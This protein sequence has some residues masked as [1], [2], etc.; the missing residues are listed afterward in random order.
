[1]TLQIFIT[2]LG[3]TAAFG[4]IALRT[5]PQLGL[6]DRPHKYGFKRK[7]IPY[8]GGVAMIL[9]FFV[10]VM[11]FFPVDRPVLAVLLGGGLLGIVSFVD[12]RQGLPAWFRLVVQVVSAVL[13]VLGGIG[14]ASITN[15]LG[16]TIVLDSIQ[17]PVSLGTLTFTITLF[18]DL[19]TVVW[20]LTMVN[21]FNWIDGVPGMANSV[22]AV[23]ALVL[24][25]LALRPDFHSM[26]QT[27]AISLSALVLGMTLGHLIFDFPPPRMI[28]GDTG[29]MLV[30][31]LL[32]VAA[33]ISGGKIA[34]TILVLGF[35]ILDFVW[36]ILRRIMKGKSPLKGDLWH[37]HHRL[38]KAGFSDRKIVLFFATTAMVFG[39][40]SLLL[41]TEGKFLA[42][43][44][45]LAVMALLALMLYS[46]RNL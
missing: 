34:T 8:P 26:D 7:A 46:K 28:V 39:C 43:F 33:I 27:L 9:A 18:A 44:A 17:F 12:D 13:L 37:F 22:G 31:F 15:P 25:S 21:A 3:F 20:V 29:S 35:P 4:W 5:F 32:A 10:T 23:A 2:A 11:M 24:L 42:F 36:V 16:G 38:Q 1:M 41:H 40:L 30:G 19:L 6:V 14:I 45:I